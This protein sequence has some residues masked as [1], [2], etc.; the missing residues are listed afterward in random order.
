MRRS[1]I[2]RKFEDIVTFAG[3][4][5]FMDTPVK[6]YSS[7]MGLRLAFAVAAHLDAEVLLVDEVLA[8]GDAS[9]QQKCLGK[10]GEVAAEGR[11]VVFVSHQMPSV[12]KLCSRAILLEKGTIV[13]DGSPSMVIGRYLGGGGA[14]LGEK[15][16]A[17]HEAPGGATARIRAVRLLSEDGAV[18]ET[19]DSRRSFGIEI[20]FDV[21]DDGLPVVPMLAVNDDK[22][23]HVFNAMHPHPRWLERPTKGAHRARAVVPANLFNDGMLMVSAFVNT[24]S[25]M[26]TIKHAYAP[27][28]VGI[29]VTV[30]AEIDSAKGNFAGP[31]GGAICPRLTWVIDAPRK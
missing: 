11:T 28:A 10:L 8:V 2:E 22:G 19:L 17:L 6:R 4:E 13:E 5:R 15:V 18:I 7:G 30:P 20:E 26:K 23:V 1:E 31:W 12:S 3:V 29:H 24:I 14:S 25:P 27:D 9:F 16:W 21:L